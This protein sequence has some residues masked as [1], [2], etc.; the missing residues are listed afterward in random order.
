MAGVTTAAH[1]FT[2]VYELLVDGHGTARALASGERFL[3]RRTSTK[4]RTQLSAR[5]KPTPMVD[6][7]VPAMPADFGAADEL[8]DDHLYHLTILVRRY[9]HL[10]FE[11]DP[12]TVE[13]LQVRM[14]NDR[15]RVRAVLC[16]PS[17]M[18]TTQAGD[19]TGIS[20]LAPR[21]S[22][23]ERSEPFGD[24]ADRLVVITDTF[25][26]EWSFDPGS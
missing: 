12:D 14:M 5:A 10:R 1:F 21:G 20:G 4:D 13:A 26:A 2:R 9:Y 23:L 17:N 19:D 8:T 18:L 7:F 11:S 3:R 15:A 22:A 25:E 16:H 24:G 6:V